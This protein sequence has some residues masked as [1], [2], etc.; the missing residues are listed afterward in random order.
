MRKYLLHILIISFV[1]L[2]MPVLHSAE[3]E[4]D[5]SGG[6]V[7]VPANLTI[8]KEPSYGGAFSFNLRSSYRKLSLSQVQSMSNISIRKKK[9]WGFVVHST[10][11]HSYNLRTRNGDKVVV[12]NATG[13]MW[14]Q[15]G[16]SGKSFAYE[17]ITIMRWDEAKEWVR[18]LN[19]RGYAGYRDW[20]LP[21]VEEAASLL[22]SSKSN[23][24]YIDSVFSKK[25]EWIWT[26][27]RNTGYKA[28]SEAAWEVNLRY[29]HV[30]CTYINSYS[31]VRPVRSMR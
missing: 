27:D 17:S 21:T 25:Q 7:S 6:K 29:G 16:F 9:D 18:N 24:L 5:R 13:L 8:Q 12:D 11:S 3:E 19:S 1:F 31:S 26:G 22:E 14:H 15:N 30:L 2:F 10:I 4:S 28:N 20:R 23:G